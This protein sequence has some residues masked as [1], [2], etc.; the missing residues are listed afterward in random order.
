[1]KGAAHLI[2]D[3]EWVDDTADALNSSKQRIQTC[4]IVQIS[5]RR[6]LYPPKLT[7]MQ[8]LS[9]IRAI[10]A[11]GSI[12]MHLTRNTIQQLVRFGRSFLCSEPCYLFFST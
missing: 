11:L 12:R 6:I 5:N 2:A 10:P 1:M 4:H 3:V 8:V 9:P 7:P